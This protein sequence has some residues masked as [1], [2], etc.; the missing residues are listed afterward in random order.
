M[1]KLPENK[2]LYRNLIKGINTWVVNIVR[3]TGPFLKWTRE[4]QIDQRTKKKKNSW[5]C[6]RLYIPEM[7]FTDYICQ[8]KKEGHASIKDSVDAS[9]QRRENYI[10][11]SGGWLITATRNITDNTSIKRTKIAKII[12]VWTFYATK[13]WNL[14]QENLDM[15]KKGKQEKNWISSNSDTIVRIP[16]V[17]LDAVT[18]GLV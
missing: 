2:Q 10:K 12:S 1:R 6:I 3:Y 15:G 9:M 11:Q 8:E 16:I 5:R 13:K 18:K 14:T 4:E 17:V 7:M